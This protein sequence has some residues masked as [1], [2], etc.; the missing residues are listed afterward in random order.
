M[1]PWQKEGPKVKAKEEQL[2]SCSKSKQLYVKSEY[3][4]KG[5]FFPE[6]EQRV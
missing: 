4:V 2:I 5:N 3:P 6:S 1:N